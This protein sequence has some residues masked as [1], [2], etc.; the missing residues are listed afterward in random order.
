MPTQER[1]DALGHRRRVPAALSGA[2]HARHRGP[3]DFQPAAETTSGA[4]CRFPGTWRGSPLPRQREGWVGRC[5]R[6]LRVELP[7]VKG[8]PLDFEHRPDVPLRLFGTAGNRARKSTLPVRCDH[9][10]H[11]HVERTSMITRTVARQRRFHGLLPEL[12]PT[13]N[14]TNDRRFEQ[15]QRVNDL[16]RIERQLQAR[17]A[18]VGVPDDVSPARSG[19]AVAAR[20]HGLSCWPMLKDCAPGSGFVLPAY[21]RR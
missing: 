15:R 10:S 4:P 8:W 7:L 9:V 1:G 6:A 13:G 18:A 3:S 20:R 21:P 5:A 16:R 12:L 11:E 14:E 17:H 19:D 2:S